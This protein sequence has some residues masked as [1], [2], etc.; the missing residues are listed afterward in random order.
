MADITFP[1]TVC[2]KPLVVD[3]SLVGQDVACPACNHVMTVPRVR[4]PL[5]VKGRTAATGSARPATP[6]V[7]EN[8]SGLAGVD[9]FGE[10]RGQLVRRRR[11]WMLAGQIL[12]AAGMLATLV[13]VIYAGYRFFDARET[14]KHQ[15]AEAFL[16]QEQAQELRRRQRNEARRLNAAARH[17]QGV[18]SLTD[19]VCYRLWHVLNACH[20]VPQEAQARFDFWVTCDAE[21]HGLFSECYAALRSPADI[22]PACQR[23]AGF[24]LGLQGAPV[25]LP[26]LAEFRELARLSLTETE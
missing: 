5:A 16:R 17:K 1:C 21:T 20:P 24:A 13:A 18:W 6:P 8:L 11:R 15:T 3:E 25:R 4:A 14:R 19:E 2:Q 12:A 22:E 7:S 23:L 9:A 26:P 10:D